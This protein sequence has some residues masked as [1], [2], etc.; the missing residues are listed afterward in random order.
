MITKIDEIYYWDEYF[1]QEE[2]EYVWED[3]DKFKWEFTGHS[4]LD[5]EGYNHERIFW[6][7]DLTGAGFIHQL[8]KIKTE[9][10]LNNKII[11]QRFYANGQAHGQTAW[12]HKDIQDTVSGGEW[13]SLIYY[14]HR[15]WKPLYGGNLN[16]VDDTKTKVTN[17]FF[18]KTNSAILFNSRSNHCALEPTVY[19]R[20]QRISIAFKFK[21]KE[22]SDAE[23]VLLEPQL[24]PL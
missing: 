18:P 5:E 8:F 13:G 20:H 19:C 10:F 9:L 7:K 16:I 11:T 23:E 22:N 2:Y 21:I 15:D 1:T 3:F 4:A 6:Y 14:L 17:T 12:L 24:R